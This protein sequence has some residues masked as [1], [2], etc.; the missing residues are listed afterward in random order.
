MNKVLKNK[1]IVQVIL[2]VIVL[3]FF[4]NYQ[5]N[6]LKSLANVDITQYKFFTTGNYEDNDGMIDPLTNE[7]AI[8]NFRMDWAYYASLKKIDTNTYL[9]SSSRVQVG[10][11]IEI[12]LKDFENTDFEWYARGGAVDTPYAKLVDGPTSPSYCS[13]DQNNGSA[14]LRTFNVMVVMSGLQ[15]MQQFT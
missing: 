1:R 8:L 11:T 9:D 5:N 3:A 10:D 4:T 2:M 15:I 7:V 12:R 14:H 6:T 13:D